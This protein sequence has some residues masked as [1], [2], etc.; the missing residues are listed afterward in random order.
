[1]VGRDNLDLRHLQR[2]G[3][4]H[5]LKHGGHTVA[6]NKESVN[7]GTSAAHCSACV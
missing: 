6:Q 3:G 5:V 4:P 2:P 1:M 7:A